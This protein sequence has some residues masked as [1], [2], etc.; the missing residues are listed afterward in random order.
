MS[1]NVAEPEGPQ[2]TILRI[3]GACWVSKATRTRQYPRARTHIRRQIFNTCCFSTATMSCERAAPPCLS[4]LVLSCLVLSCAGG[5][6][7]TAW[8]SLKL[9]LASS[10]P[11]PNVRMQNFRFLEPG[12]LCLGL[13]DRRIVVWFQAGP[14][15]FYDMIFINCN[16]VSTRW[17]WS[18][19]LYTDRKYTTI[20]MKRNSL[21][22][23]TKTQN[24][25]K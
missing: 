11:L 13:R 5:R 20:Y 12:Q 24:H 17:Q 3:R 14:G 4:C 15:Y 1:K 22:N 16:W 2:I 21:Q 18:V 6:L 8:H 19:N 10:I 25:T 9:I 7:T 23:N